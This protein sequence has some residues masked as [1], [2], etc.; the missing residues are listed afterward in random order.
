MLS[1]MG[2]GRDQRQPT[3][4]SLLTLREVKQKHV[5]I[6]LIHSSSFILFELAVMMKLVVGL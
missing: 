3:L 6:P 4:G 5:I 2:N 1:G